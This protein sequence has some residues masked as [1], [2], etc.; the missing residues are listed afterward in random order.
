M[1]LSV[2]SLL[3]STRRQWKEWWQRTRPQCSLLWNNNTRPRCSL[4]WN[5]QKAAM[6]IAMKHGHK[7]SVLTSAQPQHQSTSAGPSQVPAAPVINPGSE[8]VL[9]ERER[10][11]ETNTEHTPSFI[12][13]EKFLSVL[14]TS[15]NDLN[16]K[17]CFLACGIC[18]VKDWVEERKCFEDL[19]QDFPPNSCFRTCC[20]RAKQNTLLTSKLH[21]QYQRSPGMEEEDS[22][23]IKPLARVDK[24][25]LYPEINK[26]S[27]GLLSV[28]GR[29]IHSSLIPKPLKGLLLPFQGV[30]SGPPGA[31]TVRNKSGHMD[32]SSN[33]VIRAYGNALCRHWL[34]YSPYA[35]DLPCENVLY[36][37]QQR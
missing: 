1:G 26:V 28:S 2:Q 7:T 14:N 35:I 21:F 25:V 9:R 30:G 32:L 11:S 4:Q 22:P 15:T 33:C 27:G 10:A 13:N 6:L 17:S 37:V 19:N 24:K 34:N 29:S 5:G 36:T 3:P 12:K 18:I 8:W 20:G 31:H 23:A 16:I